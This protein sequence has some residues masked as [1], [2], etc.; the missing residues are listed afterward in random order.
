[1]KWLLFLFFISQPAFAQDNPWIVG[2]WAYFMKIFQNVEMPLNP[3]SPNHL[4][5][6]FSANGESH[7]Y[8]WNT[9]LE[10]HCERRGKYT[11]DGEYLVDT[12]TWVDPKNSIDCGSDPD[13][14]LGKTARTHVFEKNSNL[15]VELNLG[16][17]PLYYVWK[18]RD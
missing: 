2:N 9:E 8:W 18:R 17:E 5:F 15:Y 14:Q 7:L 6:D 16:N 11:L 12:V 4:H 3:T 1:M 13:M 10:T